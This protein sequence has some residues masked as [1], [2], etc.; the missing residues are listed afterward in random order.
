MDCTEEGGAG[1]CGGGGT[2]GVSTEWSG[3]GIGYD[4]IRKPVIYRNDSESVCSVEREDDMILGGSESAGE[5][6]KD[7]HLP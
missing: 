6:I 1:S 3:R 5:V 7:R 4:A 2:S